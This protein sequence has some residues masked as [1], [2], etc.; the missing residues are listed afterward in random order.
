[1]RLLGLL[2]SLSGCT[3]GGS[4]LDPG[5][6]QVYHVLFIGN[7]LTS[8][9]DLPGTVALLAA[10]GGDS[11]EVEAVARAGFALID[12]VEGK[13]DAV[14]VI[15]SRQWDYVLLQQG[16]SSL[17]LSR[18]TL[19]LATRLLDPDVRAAGGRV[20]E[21]MVWPA[22]DDIGVFDQVRLS[23]QEAARAVDGLFLPG[24]E[25]WRAAWALD[26]SV[27][28]Y[29]EDGFHPSELGTFLASLV[30][31]EAITGRDVRRLPPSAFAAGHRL[32][33]SAG[34]VRLLQ[35]AAHE[36]IVRYASGSH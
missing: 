28:L 12:H 22:K 19:I 7:S 15:R 23:Y 20:A 36:T 8:V 4:P 16:P 14:P 30:A 11:I 13:S 25:A 5:T 10:A 21:L 26:P 27:A 35:R 32:N 18:D 3:G 2:V 9:N 1:M 31:Y 34:T 24:G 33:V 29:G 17:P 6:S